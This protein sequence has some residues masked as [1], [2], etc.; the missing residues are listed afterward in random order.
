MHTGNYL[1]TTQAAEKT[2]ELLELLA[3]GGEKLRIG[4]LAGRMGV[5]RKE[6]LLLLV[7][8]ESRAVLRWDE[9]ARVYRPG[10]KTGEMVRQYLAQAGMQAVEASPRSTKPPRTTGSRTARAEMR[11][12]SAGA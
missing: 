3:A 6:A 5:S 9:Q 7:T 4:E 12:V 2:L 1:P 8:L 11:R 10:R